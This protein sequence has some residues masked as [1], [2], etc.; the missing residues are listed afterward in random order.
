MKIENLTDQKMSPNL[1]F[2]TCQTAQSFYKTEAPRKNLFAPSIQASSRATDA[3][4]RF[5]FQIGGWDKAKIK[6]IVKWL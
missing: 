2:L 6:T 5:R 4:L 1:A 3:D